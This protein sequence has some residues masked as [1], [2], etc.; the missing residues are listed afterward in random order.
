[1]TE[2]D[3]PANRVLRRSVL[4]FQLSRNIERTWTELA[5][6]DWTL[7]T[8][9]RFLTLNWA[10]SLIFFFFEA[11]KTKQTNN[12]KN[13]NPCIIKRSFPQVRGD[14]VSN[15]EKLRPSELLMT[16]EPKCSDFM[17]GGK[18]FTNCACSEQIQS[19][20]PLIHV[21]CVGSWVEDPL[22][23]IY[24]SIYLLLLIFSN[25]GMFN[26]GLVFSVLSTS[27]LKHTAWWDVGGEGLI[28]ENFRW[29]SLIPFWAVKQLFTLVRAP[30]RCQSRRWHTDN[31]PGS[32][33]ICCPWGCALSAG[34]QLLKR[35]GSYVHLPVSI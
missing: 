11:G 4:I 29:L 26:K 19:L 27:A 3:N 8:T 16:P 17:R 33:L 15:V 7:G 35:S 5:H 30:W 32:V 1:M 10:L 18:S 34:S 6:K 21:K 28:R 20:Q 13:E 12:N 23:F 14:G 2:L 9:D 22:L 31:S 25:V 24:L